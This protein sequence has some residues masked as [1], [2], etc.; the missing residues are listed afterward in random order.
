[1]R[2]KILLADDSLTAQSTGKKILAAAGYDVTTVS[3]GMAAARQIAELHP[4]L[5]LLDVYMPGYT[6]IEICEKTKAAPETAHLPVLLTVGKMEPFRVE[7][8]IKVKADGVIIKPF[9]AKVLTTLVDKLAQ[10]EPTT[11]GEQY[12]SFVSNS[13][14]GELCDVCGHVNPATASVC[15]Q[16]DVP[17]PSSIMSLRSTNSSS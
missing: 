7:E 12:P 8:G 9:E 15:E 4:D 5:A 11:A 3:N 1:M 14:G 16:C 17:L 13:Q 2:L 10:H 6:G